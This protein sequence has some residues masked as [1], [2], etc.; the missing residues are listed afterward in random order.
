M[1]SFQAGDKIR[2]F[3]RTFELMNGDKAKLKEVILKETAII[4]KNYL[5]YL[6]ECRMNGETPL[7]SEE[8]EKEYF[9][10]EGYGL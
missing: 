6:A 5:E 2:N 4:R 10:K 9:N 8:F 1:Y 3:E 7:S